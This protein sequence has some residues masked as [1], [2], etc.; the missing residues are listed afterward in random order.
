MK[1]TL[2]PSA[3]VLLSATRET[4]RKTLKEVSFRNI[5]SALIYRDLR[6]REI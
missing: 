3:R 4:R 6:L 5:S 2:A 1:V